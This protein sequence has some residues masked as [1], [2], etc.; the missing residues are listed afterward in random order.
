MGGLPR[1]RLI[2]RLSEGVLE[3]AESQGKDEKYASA[4]ATW[5]A[6]NPLEPSFEVF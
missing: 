5:E 2:V 6:W 4:A 1:S 3:A